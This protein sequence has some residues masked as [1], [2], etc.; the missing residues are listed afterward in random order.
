MRVHG[1]EED[2]IVDGVGIRLA[3][4]L[5]GCP[6]HC[7][8]CH[9]PE[10]WDYEGV[11]EEYSVSQVLELFDT[12]KGLLAGIT[13]S[14]G[15]PLSPCHMPEI[16]E[17]CKEIKQ[18]GKTVWIFTG[19]TLESAVEV[20]PNIVTDLLPYV[21]TI[22]DGPFIESEKDLLLKFRGSKNQR[23]IDVKKWLSSCRLF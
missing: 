16:I 2:S 9:N 5:Q 4:F 3:V 12:E 10:T 11:C 22:V 23:I 14:G 1:I 17:L 20:F 8:G 21:D 18:R 15:E 7:K 13:L 19:Y 6:H